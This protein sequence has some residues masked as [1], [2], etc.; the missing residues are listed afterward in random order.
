MRGVGGPVEDPI[1]LE[2]K[3]A[4][5]I[6]FR[7][8]PAPA[9][10]RGRIIALDGEGGGVV[11]VGVMMTETGPQEDTAGGGRDGTRWRSTSADNIREGLE[12]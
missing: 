1:Y 3:A 7:E 5:G 9:T 4:P 10:I 12:G 8:L 6:H 2:A 11:V